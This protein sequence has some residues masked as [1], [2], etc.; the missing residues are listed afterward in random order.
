MTGML[1]ELLHISELFDLYGALLTEKQ[2]KCLELHL[3]EDF[4]LSEIAESMGISR[5]AV[6]DMLHR[7]EQTMQDY[8]AKLGFLAQSR[9]V[10]AEL[11]AEEYTVTVGGGMV[12]LTMTGKHQVTSVKIDPEAV[13]PDD[14]E[15]LEDLL[16]AAVNEAVRVVGED[17]ETRLGAVTG[18]LN[19]PGLG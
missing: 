3:F 9:K 15:M 6:Y 18:G 13:S 4:S 7:S 2:Q 5:Q 12:Q 17:S 1:E 11:A 16:A 10:Q 8:E 19:V 14:V